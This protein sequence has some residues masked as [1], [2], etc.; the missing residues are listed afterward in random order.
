MEIVE[1][2]SVVAKI[3]M[4]HHQNLADAHA[5]YMHFTGVRS[6]E[7]D[8]A[9]I[10][11]DRAQFAHLLEFTVDGKPALSDKRCAEFMAAVT[12]L[13]VEWCAAWDE[14]DFCNEHGDEFFDRQLKRQES[15]ISFIKGW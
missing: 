15:A 9:Q 10:A 1:A 13:S 4:S 2:R 6:D 8:G 14:V 11:R 3:P 12:G 5:R 7:V